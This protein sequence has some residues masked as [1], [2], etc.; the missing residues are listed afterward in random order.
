MI[1]SDKTGTLTQNSM[2][3]TSF[4]NE[5]EVLFKNML[6]VIRVF[7]KV[8]IETFK[9]TGL[10]KVFPNQN[11]QDIFLQTAIINSSAILVNI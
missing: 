9:K 3:F 1:C 2:T 4:W 10:N 6:F 5:K 8:E 7:K 11:L